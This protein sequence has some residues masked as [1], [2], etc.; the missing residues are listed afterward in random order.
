MKK[1][2][3]WM[4]LSVEMLQDLSITGINQRL[5]CYVF[6]CSTCEFMFLVNF[7]VDADVRMQT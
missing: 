2:S 1:L 7:I 6:L 5:L 4:P 3:A